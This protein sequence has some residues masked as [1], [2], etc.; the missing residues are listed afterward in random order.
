M[1]KRDIKKYSLFADCLA[2][3]R[4][5]AKVEAK[6]GENVM[7]LHVSKH[8]DTIFISPETEIMKVTEQLVGEELSEDPA[9]L[10]V[11]E[12]TDF[13]EDSEVLEEEYIEE[14]IENLQSEEETNAQDV[15]DCTLAIEVETEDREVSSR[16]RRST[17]KKYIYPTNTNDKL[18]DEERDWIGQQVENSEVQRDGV[19]IYK[20]PLCDTY[21]KIAASLKKHLRDTHILKSDKQVDV[22]N[23]RQALKD[24]IKRSKMVI[25]TSSGPE[26]IWKCSRCTTNRIFR[27]ESGL[28]VHIRYN[29]IRSQVIDPSFIAQCRI[30]NYF[31]TKDGWTC[32]G[33]PK[34][35]RSR[36]AFR[37]HLK[38]EHQDV[39]ESVRL[40]GNASVAD[41]GTTS[42]NQISNEDLVFLLEKKQRRIIPEH[43][44]IACND[45]G[46]EFVNGKSKREKSCRI[47]N[48]CH[49][50]LKVV[51][52]YYQL[53]KHYDSRTVFSN[54][55]HLKCFLINDPSQFEPYPCDGMVSKI[56]FQLKEPQS[57]SLENDAW[58]CGHCSARY[59][60][61]VECISHVMILHSKSLICPVDHLEFSGRRGVSQF[62]I[63]MRNKHS[64]MFP[65][66]RI[67]C[68][69]CLE[70]FATIFEKLAHMKT[71]SA[72]K[73]QCDHCSKSYFTKTELIRH[74][75]IVSGE[76]KYVC[77]FCQKI[78]SS[79]MDL[80]LHQTAH[81]NQKSYAC[82]YPGCHKAFK[83]PAA[84]SSHLETHSNVIFACTFCPSSFKQRALLQRHIR[85][86]YCKG[87]NSKSQVV[88]ED[89]QMFEVTEV[90]N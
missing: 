60:T 36:E 46:I 23:S 39:V 20:C 89:N 9:E 17:T 65:D 6:L 3:L 62:N 83:T 4:I 21:L 37:N 77:N 1:F 79:T 42:D 66:I 13:P 81:T 87:Q 48:E 31:G 57:S 50:I 29:H 28:K 56:S 88:V 59:Q 84:R 40:E 78:C 58:K 69:Y 45:C 75:K 22:K 33:C 27:S 51:S 43:R 26:T 32:P 34:V 47:H 35:L 86:G 71:C 16:P 41:E 61:E 7:D 18:T 63:H 30:E 80:K 5:L 12:Q 54:D 52:Q 19:V 64:E 85:K 82:S 2:N 49:K 44:S 15:R 67:Q 55:E 73:F 24:E 90:S 72:K 53:P 11:C 38:L 70:E 68:T 74:L 10:D 14:Q 25:E 8:D 76:I